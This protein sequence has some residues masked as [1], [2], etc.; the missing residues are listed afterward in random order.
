MI[1][2][3][4]GYFESSRHMLVA[5]QKSMTEKYLASDLIERVFTDRSRFPFEKQLIHLDTDVQA[6]AYILEQPC[7]DL[8]S[9]EQSDGDLDLFNINVLRGLPKGIKT[10]MDESQLAACEDML[11]KSVAVIQGPPGTGKTFVSVSALKAMTSNLRLTDPP[12]I[13]A[14]QSNHAVDQ[15][16]NH[17]LEFE[18]EILRLG[19]QSDKSNKDIQTRTLF[20]LRQS[21]ASKLSVNATKGMKNAAAEHRSICDEIKI[22]LWPLLKGELLTAETL[23]KHDLITK[24]QSES[25][26]LDEWA[27]DDEENEE[28]ADIAS[29]MFFITTDPSSPLQC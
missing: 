18:P 20:A 15:M 24:A 23:L 4:H 19:S 11:T 22:V 27:E 26:K 14:A 21:H 28:K 6:P 2:P 10:T 1:E 5:M 3:R 7:L 9:L 17:I 12:I 29:C 8:T 16:L 13:V 25:L